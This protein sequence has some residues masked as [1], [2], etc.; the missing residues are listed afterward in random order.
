MSAR[1]EFNAV[2]AILAIVFGIITSI[3]AA[4]TLY[5][6]KHRNSLW[7][8][9]AMTLILLIISL[10]Q[11]VPGCVRLTHYSKK[12][13]EEKIH[14]AFAETAECLHRL[15]IFI[16]NWFVSFKFW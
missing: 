9:K 1:D 5:V 13:E 12:E 6:I 2:N 11:I 15:G 7:Y 8:L 16:V 3:A 10:V 14:L 4:Y